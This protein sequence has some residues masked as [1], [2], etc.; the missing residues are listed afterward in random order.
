M[1]KEGSVTR[2]IY[3]RINW[4]K[5]KTVIT[6]DAKWREKTGTLDGAHP[7]SSYIY[8]KPTRSRT[9]VKISFRASQAKLLLNNRTNCVSPRR[10]SIL[11]KA[12]KVWECKELKKEKNKIGTEGRGGGRECHPTPLIPPL[13]L[14]LN[15]PRAPTRQDCY[16]S[17]IA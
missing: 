5:V 7:K 12:Q 4:L 6:E 2:K 3:Q 9:A 13:Y 15:A 8:E 17:K 1:G 14:L 16:P 11:S 10:S